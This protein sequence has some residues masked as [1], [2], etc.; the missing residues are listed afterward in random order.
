MVY[1][2]RGR[3]WRDEELHSDNDSGNASAHWL[4][5]REIAS[6]GALRLRN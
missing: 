5:L 3:N 2:V 6:L 1:T 4:G